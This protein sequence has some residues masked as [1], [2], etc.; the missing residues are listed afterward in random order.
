LKTIRFAFDRTHL[1]IRL[2]GIRRL[3]DLL[4]EGYEFSLKFLQP[5]GLRFSVKEA[6]GQVS[7]AFWERR[8]EGPVWESRGQ[9]HA[10][11]VAGTVLEIGLPLKDLNVGRVSALSFFVAVYD[12]TN[13]EIERHPAYRPIVAAVPDAKYE[14]RNWTA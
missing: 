14:A 13:A 1:Y 10:M 6:Y 2:D 7:S 9:D 4:G 8:Q 3:R 12:P 11:A 5:E